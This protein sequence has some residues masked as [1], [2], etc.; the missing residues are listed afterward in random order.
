MSSQSLIDLALLPKL[1]LHAHLNGS[2]RDSTLRELLSALHVGDVS[3]E[4]RAMMLESLDAR[5]RTL[6]DC[7][8]IFDAIHR[9]TSTVAATERIAAEVVE[10]FADQ[11]C[12][13]LELRTT[14]KQTQ[15]MSKQDYVSA[16]LRGIARG[17]AARAID[18]GLLLSINRATDSAATALE[19]VELARAFRDAGACVYGVELSGNPTKGDVRLFADAIAAAHRHALGVSIHIGEVA[20]RDD[21][22]MALLAM[23]PHRIGHAVFMSDAARAVVQERRVPIEMCLT[24]NVLTDSVASYAD[25]HMREYAA[26]GHPLVLC[27]DDCAVFGTTLT[28]EYELA[29]T[30]LGVSD[31]RFV[32]LAR[33]AVDC[34]LVWPGAVRDKVRARVDEQLRT[35]TEAKQARAD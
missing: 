23:R 18:V 25:H 9:V 24:S 2:V 29:R 20:D 10:D 30:H 3:S 8:V 12:V 6:S 7:F 21:E 4:R 34:V 16:V 15:T 32:E 1:E 19:C 14:P 5:T 11:H 13:Y 17:V 35:L 31:A 27:T 28:R 33:S 26:S 22:L